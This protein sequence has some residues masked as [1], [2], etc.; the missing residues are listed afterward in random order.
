MKKF[1]E[2]VNLAVQDIHSGLLEGGGKEMKS[3]V[4]KWL[5]YVLEAEKEEARPKS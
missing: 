1:D 3:R 2:I 5:S 4:F